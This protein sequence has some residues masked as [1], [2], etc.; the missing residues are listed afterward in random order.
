MNAKFPAGV[1]FDDELLVDR[2]VDLLARRELQ[3]FARLVL[4][5]PIQPSGGRRPAATSRFDW[6]T[7]D[8]RLRSPI[9]ITSPGLHMN[10][11][12]V[13]D[14]AV[15]AKVAVRDELAR[16]RAAAR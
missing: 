2:R 10:D 11:G 15:D 3:Y 7:G 13:H 9:E 14:A 1:I 4:I 8:F 6:K 16:L 5:V 12:N